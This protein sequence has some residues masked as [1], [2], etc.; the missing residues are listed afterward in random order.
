MTTSVDV[1]FTDRTAFK[2][3]PRTSPSLMGTPSLLSSSVTTLHAHATAP[4]KTTCDIDLS[5]T[6]AHG[7]TTTNADHKTPHHSWTPGAEWTGAPIRATI[8]L[9]H[10]KLRAGQVAPPVPTTVTRTFTFA[11]SVPPAGVNHRDRF[12]R[13]HM[14]SGDEDNNEG[15]ATNVN[16]VECYSYE[17]IVAAAGLSSWSFEELRVECYAQSFIARGTKPAPAVTPS[18]TIP[19][20]FVPRTVPR[21]S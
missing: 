2:F 9:P 1:Q 20:A 3:L 8:P 19:P 18:L 4:T 10:R 6:L 15:H 17:S 12:L 11:T 5:P 7:T 14:D 13:D 21:S 16:Q